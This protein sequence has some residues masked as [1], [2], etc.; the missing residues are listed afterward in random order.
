MKIIDFVFPKKCLECK[1]IGKYICSSCLDKVRVGGAHI[2]SY[3][4]FRYEGVIRRALIALKYKFEF[5]LC[6]ELSEIATQKIKSRSLCFSEKSVLIPVPL[7]TQRKRWRG[8]N[9]TEILGSKIASKLGWDF[10][11]N[12]VTK[13]KETKT[14]VELSGDERRTNLISSFYL[15][16]DLLSK[17]RD[18]KFIIFDDVFTTGATINEIQ[19]LFN[20][21]KDVVGLTIAG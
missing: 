1:R 19:K 16:I 14:Q 4:T 13:V 21:K 11:P 3:S 20:G 5:D 7:T 9:Q 18:K 10:C 2:N 15:N 6:D 17:L 8:F 12:L